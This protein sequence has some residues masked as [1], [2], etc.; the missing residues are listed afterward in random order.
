MCVKTTFVFMSA[1]NCAKYPF[2][3]ES[4]TSLFSLT[5]LTSSFYSYPISFRYFL[6]GVEA[7]QNTGNL[8]QFGWVRNWFL[9]FHSCLN[10]CTTD[11][12]AMQPTT[13]RSYSLVKW[14]VRPLCV[15]FDG[16][17]FTRSLLIKNL[18]SMAVGVWLSKEADLMTASKTGNYLAA[19]ACVSIWHLA[20]CACAVHSLKVR[21]GGGWPVSHTIS[22]LSKKVYYILL[23]IDLDN[24][25]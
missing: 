6:I 22:K 24:G 7:W 12:G 2:L 1:S 13:R 21:E 9:F 3:D 8:E 16:N 11:L 25:K 5:I 19:T 10:V 17:V 23:K 4:L 15:K 20:Q 14:R 18:L